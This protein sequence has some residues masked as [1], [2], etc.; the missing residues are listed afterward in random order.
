MWDLLWDWSELLKLG[1]DAVTYFLMAMVGTT[2]FLVRL[3]VALF[4]GGDGGDFH[5][6]AGGDLGAHDVGSDAAF[7]LFSLLSVMAFIMGT[8][9]MGLACRIDWGLNRP[10]SVVISVGFGIMMMFFAAGLTY[11]T[12][13]LNRQ[14]TYDVTT[15]VGRT[16]HVYM[17]IPPKGEGQGKVQ[18][19]VSGRLMTMPAVSS[20]PKL[21][22]FA[23]VK[24]IDTRDDGTLIVAP[25]S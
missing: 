3:T 15:A 24:V 2:L 6:D 12:R 10:L 9:W 17:T 1:G 25:L 22:A 19:S 14:V 23:D 5:V 13:K 8:G 4:G 21:D 18:V 20:G 7:S 11:L 16:A